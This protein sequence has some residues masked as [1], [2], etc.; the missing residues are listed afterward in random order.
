MENIIETIGPDLVLVDDKGVTWWHDEEVLSYMI[1]GKIE[2][3]QDRKREIGRIGGIR[4]VMI[5]T[6]I[7]CTKN[8][9]SR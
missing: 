2:K 8:E 3:P 9:V 1:K 7:H 4:N 6:V 5:T